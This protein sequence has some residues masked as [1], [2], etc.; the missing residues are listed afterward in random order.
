MG[1]YFSIE[2]QSAGVPGEFIIVCDVHITNCKCQ[3]GIKKHSQKRNEIARKRAF[4]FL[5]CMF[6]N[7]AAY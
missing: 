1:R 7:F 3:F 4:T 2:R 5:K 6:L